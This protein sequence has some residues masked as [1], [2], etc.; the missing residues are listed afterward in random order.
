MMPLRSDFVVGLMAGAGVL[1][2]GMM[3]G[4]APEQADQ[5]QE[6]LRA[7][8]VEIVDELGTVRLVIGY[9]AEG[10]SIS[11]RDRFGKT[12]LLAGAAEHGGMLVVTH[13]ATHAPLLTAGATE[14]GG[15]LQLFN[16]QGQRVFDALAEPHGGRVT[17]AT[18]TA[19]PALRLHPDADGAG[20]ITAFGPAGGELL[21]LYADVGGNGVIETF[22]GEGGAPLVTLSSTVGRHGQVK[23]TAPDGRPLVLI[24]ASAD[25]EGQLYTFDAEGNPMVA[26]ASAHRRPALRVFRDGKAAVTLECDENGNGS[27]GVWN[28]DGNGRTFK[29]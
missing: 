27:V 25:E 3:L 15:A 19:R 24:T 21:K 26:I 28:P 10:G 14:N 6:V 16:D 20:A 18:G 22:R 2:V 12:A 4:G 5:V 29:P 13:S 11:V 1:A 9:N 17:V 8:Q 7:R 23:T